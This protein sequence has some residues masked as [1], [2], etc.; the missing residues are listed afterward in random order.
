MSGRGRPILGL[1]EIA[2]RVRD[3]DAMRRFY[4]EVIGLEVMGLFD[5]A[6]FFRIA[7]GHAGHT[8]ILALFDRSA[9]PDYTAPEAAATS[10]DHLAFEI[11]LADFEAEKRRLEQRGCRVTT[12]RHAWVHWR[13]LY[14]FDPEGN[15]VELVCYD[16]TVR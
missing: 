3:L 2:L 13:S 9:R 15:E 10:V 4:E 12:S 5:N 6:V 7:P 16:E 14:L 11:A 1:G 8:Q